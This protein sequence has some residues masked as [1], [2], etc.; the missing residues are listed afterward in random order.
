MKPALFLSTLLLPFPLIAHPDPRHTLEHLEEH[1]A[2]SPDDAELLREKA[3]L[4][5][6]TGQPDLARPVVDRLL[7]L[8]PGVPENLLLD[9]RVCLAKNDPSASTK[10]S[11]LTASHPKFAPGWNLLAR[12]ERI[13]G[14]RDEAITAKRRYLE[15]ARKPAPGDVLTCATWIAEAGDTDSAI[16]ILDQGLAKLGVLTGLHQKAIDLELVLGRHDAALRRVDAL[17]ARFRPSVELSLR[18]AEILEKAGRPAQA[19]AACDD[20]LALL[21]SLPAK[22]KQEDAYRERF[23]SITKRKSDNLAR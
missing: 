9:A 4:L 19:A 18:R 6:A 5:L 23:E 12:V 8:A 16:T 11:A 7:A 20:A 17:A 10:A 21:D 13:K 1:L 3:G 2:E 15:L 22:R 14:R